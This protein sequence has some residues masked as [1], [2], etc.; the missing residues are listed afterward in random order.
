MEAAERERH[1]AKYLKTTNQ[2]NLA[3]NATFKRRGYLDKACHNGAGVPARFVL[4][5][6]S[7][8]DDLPDGVTL[9]IGGGR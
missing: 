6:R 4:D 9:E 3:P 5:V 7:Q 8:L 1:R 2:P